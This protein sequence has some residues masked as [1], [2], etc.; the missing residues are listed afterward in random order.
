[1]SARPPCATSRKVTE[2]LASAAC[3]ACGARSRRANRLSKTCPSASASI[4]GALSR[5][6]RHWSSE[7][8]TGCVLNEELRR[9]RR[10]LPTHSSESVFRPAHPAPENQGAACQ[11][12]VRTALPLLR[13][14][15]QPSCAR[16]V[17][18][19]PPPRCRAVSARTLLPPPHTPRKRQSA[20]PGLGGGRPAI[21]AAAPSAGAV[22]ARAPSWP[23]ELAPRWQS[24]AKRNLEGHVTII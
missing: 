21:R 6:E 3:R 16:P 8:S 19:T 2:K 9:K 24:P 22:F 17:L 13:S 10:Q 23:I 7:R 15:R 20:S 14:D 1:M 4:S 5:N 18:R 11:S 12:S